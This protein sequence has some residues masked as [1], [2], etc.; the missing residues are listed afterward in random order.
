MNMLVLF[1][2]GPII[3]TRLGATRFILLYFLSAMGSVGLHI[4]EIWLSIQHYEGL[5][6]T[7]ATNPTLQHL[8]EFFAEIDTTQ[9]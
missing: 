3:E 2:L 4:G 5:L 6:E 1:F 9:N 8:N 7:F